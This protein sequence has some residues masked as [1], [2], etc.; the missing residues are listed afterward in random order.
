MFKKIVSEGVYWGMKGD[1]LEFTQ[2]YMWKNAF[3]PKFYVKTQFNA[4][5]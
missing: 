4:L 1:T 3:G 5:L 2:F